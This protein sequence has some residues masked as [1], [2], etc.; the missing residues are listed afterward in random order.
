MAMESN[1]KLEKLNE[2][3]EYRTDSIKWVNV[4]KDKPGS[5]SWKSED[6]EQHE[7]NNINWKKHQRNQQQQEKPT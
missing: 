4:R 2:S 5:G 7:M 1:E 6:V 3:I